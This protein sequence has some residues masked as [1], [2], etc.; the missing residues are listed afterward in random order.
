MTEALPIDPEVAKRLKSKKG[1]ISMVI[2]EAIDQIMDRFR[3]SPRATTCCTSC[4]PGA[5]KR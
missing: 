4:P 1:R 5:E 2:K 3:N